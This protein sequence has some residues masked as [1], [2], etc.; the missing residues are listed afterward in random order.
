VLTEQPLLPV[1]WSAD[2]RTLLVRDLGALP[3]T[4]YQID[5]PTGHVKPWK[6]IR[7]SDLAG[8]RAIVRLFVT[9]D[10]RFY[11]YSFERDLAQLYLTDG[12]K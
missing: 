9:P 12:W 8:L 10:E 11:A 3:A 4:L 6:K 7:P 1:V 5:L 2:G